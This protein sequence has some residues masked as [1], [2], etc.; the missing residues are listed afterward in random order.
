MRTV[1]EILESAE[2]MLTWESR[3]VTDAQPASLVVGTGRVTR[4]S[5][6]PG[7]GWAFYAPD[8]SRTDPS[9]WFVPERCGVFPV[10]RSL[11]PSHIQWA[12]EGM[13]LDG[14]GVRRDVEYALQRIHRG[15]WRKVVPV[16]FATRPAPLSPG[17]QR[18]LFGNAVQAIR[19]G[20]WAYG[21]RGETEGVVGVTP[22]ILFRVDAHGT[23][24]TMALAG[25]QP[26]A[27]REGEVD[28]LAD[29]KE[30]VEH[31]YVVDFLV[32]RLASLGTVERGETT[33]VEFGSLRHLHTP[34]AVRPTR[35]PDFE[36]LVDRLHPT[37]ALGAVPVEA[38]LS[39]LR[40]RDARCP[41]RR[42]GA[43][44]GAVAPNGE[45]VCVVAIRNVQWS[46]AESTIGVGCGVVAGTEPE[47]EYQEACAKV[48][49][50]RTLLG[51]IP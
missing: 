47:R 21:L 8:F 48:E 51:I 34:F 14:A 6:Y 41:R 27:R 5:R 22:E 17:E 11:G 3:G 50:I 36:T 39:W 35:C 18:A 46:Q 42:H 19:P 40:E 12:R 43:P 13:A 9:P 7:S 10:D 32:D 24:H 20:R 30:R 49:A 28:L 37:P 29:P 25:T 45:M 15:E 16:W 1:R 2:L 38:G 23:I 33:V 26:I 44:F 4:T 31:G